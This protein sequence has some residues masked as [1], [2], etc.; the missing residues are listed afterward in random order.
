MAV[1]EV[2]G[3]HDAEGA[4]SGESARLGAAQGVV[5]VAL[6]DALALWSARQIDLAHEDIART[7]WLA[8]ARVG[9]AATALAQFAAI[10]VFTGIIRSTGIDFVHGWTFLLKCGR[11]CRPAVRVGECGRGGMRELLARECAETPRCGH[12]R[13]H[14]AA[15]LCELRQL[16]VIWVWPLLWPLRCEKR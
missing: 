5:A 9:C 14:S 11:V 16:A 7:E 6:V 2:A 8:F 10:V 15:K 3:G 1:S 4:G 13:R 12:W